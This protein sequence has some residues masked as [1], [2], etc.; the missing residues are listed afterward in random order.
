MCSASGVVDCRL[1]NGRLTWVFWE[2]QSTLLFLNS[3][4]WI[5]MDGIQPEVLVVL[6][7]LSLIYEIIIGVRIRV[8][9]SYEKMRKVLVRIGKPSFGNSRLLKTRPDTRPAENLNQTYRHFV[10]T[11]IL[12]PD[13]STK[14]E[15]SYLPEALYWKKENHQIN[16]RMLSCAWVW[17]YIYV[18]EVSPYENWE[19]ILKDPLWIRIRFLLRRRVRKRLIAVK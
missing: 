13:W 10:Q 4:V 17:G 19:L 9:Q 8:Q 2:Q 16:Y 18:N 11:W 7:Y 14:S 15:R 6:L 1:L 3:E 5:E 12:A